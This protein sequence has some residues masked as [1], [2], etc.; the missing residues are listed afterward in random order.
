M[1]LELLANA[2]KGQIGTFA[3][4]EEARVPVSMIPHV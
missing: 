4:I 2:N 3:M 1:D